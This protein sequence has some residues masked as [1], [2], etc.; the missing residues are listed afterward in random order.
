[1]SLTTSV[2]NHPISD[3]PAFFVHPCNTADA[4]GEIT[5]AVGVTLDEY[6]QIWIGLVGRSVGFHVPSDFAIR[7]GADA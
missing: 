6:I 4:I 7:R 3:V 1:M 2:Q 5:G